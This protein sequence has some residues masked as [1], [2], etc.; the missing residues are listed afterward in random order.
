MNTLGN[1]LWIIF[2][3]LV[4]AISWCLAGVLWCITF[5]GIPI[6][7]QC[8]KFASLALCPFGKHVEYGGGFGSCLLNVIWLILTGIP[9]ALEHLGIGILLCITIVGIPFGSQH[10]KIAKLTL[11]PFGAKVY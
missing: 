1:V 10:F 8:F 11:F 7:I 9:L 5:V 2:G 4:S 3:G 6:G